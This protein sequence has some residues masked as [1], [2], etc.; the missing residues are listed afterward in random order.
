MDKVTGGSV[1]WNLDVDDKA[2]EAGLN[3]AKRKIDEAAKEGA[4]TFSQTSAKIGRKLTEVGKVLI[5]VGSIASGALIV[6]VNSAINFEDS[7]ADVRK[8][9][10][11]T[12]EQ[13]SAFGREI[14]NLSKNTRTSADELLNIAKIAGQLGVAKDQLIPFTEAVNQAVVAL[15]DEFTGGAEE[16]TR[17]LGVLANQFK[18]TG[19]DG[20]NIA[21]AIMGVGSAINSLGAAGQATGPYMTDFSRRVGGVAPT[22]GLTIDK[23]LGLA[24]ALQELGQSPEVAG[25]AIQQ[26]LIGMGKDV[27][28]F[29]KVAGKSTKEFSKL[30][31]TDINEAL[32]LVA[33]GVTDSSDGVEELSATLDT[34]GIDGARAVGVLANLGNN[35]DLVRKRQ[36]LANKELKAA[37]SLTEEYNIKNSTTKAELEKLRNSLK[38]MSV[39]VGSALLPAI[40]TIVNKL[41]PVIEAISRWATENPKLAATIL[42]IGASIGVLGLVLVSLGAVISSIITIAPVLGSAFTIMLG[43]VGLL[44]AGVGLLAGGLIYLGTQ[45]DIF[46]SK[47]DLLA[48]SNENVKRTTDELKTSEDNLKNA[49]F[50]LEGANLRLERAQDTYNKT[51]QQYG[52]D[53]LEAREAEY[54]LEGAKNAVRDAQE[55]VNTK[56]EENKKAMADNNKAQEEHKKV[57]QQTESAWNS[58]KDAIGSAIGKLIEWNDKAMKVGV[59]V[60]QLKL[61]GFASG[62]T[63]F[64]GGLAMVG[65]EGPELVN[66]PRGSDVIPNDA[67]SEL[68]S[69]KKRVS[70]SNKDVSIYVNQMNVNEEADVKRVGREIGFRIGINPSIPVR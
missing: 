32:L 13:T 47:Q 40:N 70:S 49:R 18:L 69:K 27:D 15:G 30:L 53:S 58:F 59:G 45:T 68:F 28:A 54:Q 65:E 21:P 37:T 42:V 23:T 38:N 35:T 12:A 50:N 19:K 62:V 36:E 29:A 25:T 14:L 22:V 10:G 24:A 3:K 8:T 48:E 6:A 41:T 64:S 16:V 17:E 44:I 26:L 11:L 5:G 60:G 46:K 51:L 57:V 63:N 43:P 55:Q 39:T 9:T 67:T 52:K 33:K 66:L 1:V 20:E 31:K 7:L 56:L 4:Q 61:P 2:F 34:L